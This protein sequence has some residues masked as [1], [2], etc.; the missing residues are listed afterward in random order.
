MAYMYLVAYSGRIHI[1]VVGIIVGPC[2]S[3]KE[4]QYDV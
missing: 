1:D 2:W 4:I 3:Y